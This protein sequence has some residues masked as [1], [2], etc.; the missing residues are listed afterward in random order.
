MEQ[1][2]KSVK[3][4]MLLNY[5][6]NGPSVVNNNNEKVYS[7]AVKLEKM[8]Q[9]FYSDQGTVQKLSE[10]MKVYRTHKEFMEANG[11]LLEYAEDETLAGYAAA[12]E[13]ISSFFKK[14]EEV[15][16]CELV[17]RLIALDE[18]HFFEDYPYAANFVEDYINFKDSPYLK[19]FLN[20]VGI[21]E[22]DFNRFLT[23]VNELDQDLFDRYQARAQENKIQRMDDVSRK[24]RNIVSGVKT[25]K[26]TDGEDFDKIE[27]Y[28]NLPFY[29]EMSSRETLEDFNIRK[30]PFIDQRFKSI[31]LALAP[32][33]TYDVLKYSLN[34][35]LLSSKSHT[36]TEKEIAETRYTV[37]GITLT[38]EGKQHIINY[39][40]E[41]KMPWL[42][43]AFQ[44]V[45]DRYLDGTLKLSENKKLAKVKGGKK[46]EN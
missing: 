20:A 26:T 17:P 1:E 13:E 43:L 44:E 36:I 14:C 25:G 3:I 31:L 30:T 27:F 16:L 32:Q 11:D 8:M 15:G 41:R 10:M 45:R 7:R 37:N 46:D 21:R 29:D 22:V 4:R 39:M 12:V 38:D 33:E 5:I 35:K 18:D 28:V 23:V 2:K 34:N 24:I 6:N 9:L 42:A 19:D 40:K